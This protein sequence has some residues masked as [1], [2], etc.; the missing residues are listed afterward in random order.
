MAT[1]SELVPEAAK[2]AAHFAVLRELS[3]RIGD[4]LNSAVAH[5]EKPMQ[6]CLDDLL[7]AV[8]SLFFAVHLDFDPRPK[9]LKP[10]N[11]QSVLDRAQDMAKCKVRTE[12]KW[13]A[14]FYFNNSLFRIDAVCHRG[15]ETVTGRSDTIEQSLVCADDLF[16]K[17]RGSDWQ[18]TNLKEINPEVIRLKHR[19]IGLIAGRKVELQGA[20]EAIRE[21]LTLLEAFDSNPSLQ[22]KS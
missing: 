2:D 3:K 19:E 11:I 1:S 12:G 6:A 18:R 9:P 14:G 4:L 5:A 13:T 15:L 22:P 20:I 10:E 16:K 7:G 21:L 8:Y 17:W